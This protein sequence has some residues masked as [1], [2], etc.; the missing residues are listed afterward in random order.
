MEGSDKNTS[1]SIELVALVYESLRA[2][3]IQKLEEIV[4][5]DVTWNVTEGFS[6]SGVYTGLHNVLRGFYGRLMSGLDKFNTEKIKWIDAGENV[7][8]LGYYL[9]TAKGEAEEHRIRFAH[10]WGIEDGKVTGVWQVADTAK[11]PPALQPP[12]G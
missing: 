6:C 5:K 4:T 8:V 9:M 2:R 3:N 12:R 1:K 10:I 7:I 11:L